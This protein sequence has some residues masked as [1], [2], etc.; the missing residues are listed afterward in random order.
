MHFFKS[1]VCVEGV[2]LD[3][4]LHACTH[5]HMQT[6]THSYTHSSVFSGRHKAGY[7]LTVI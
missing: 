4:Y 2:Y 3:T 1:S 6:H 5:I 7:Y